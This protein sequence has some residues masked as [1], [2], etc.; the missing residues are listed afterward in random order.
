MREFQDKVAVVTGGSGGIGR[1][2]AQSFLEAGMRVVLADLDVDG[3]KDAEQELS[4]YGTVL[5]IPADVSKR[6][7]VEVL[8]RRAID[9][10]GAVHILCNN[11]GLNSRAEPA[12]WELPYEEWQTVIGVNL[13]GVLNG[14]HVFVPLMLEQNTEGHIVNTASAAGLGSRPGI[15]TY[16]ATKAAVVALSESLHH[17]LAR[18][19][20]K[21]HASVLCPGRV[22]TPVRMGGYNRSR[23]ARTEEESDAEGRKMLH[24]EVGELVLNAIREE[25][26]YV[27]THPEAIKERVRSRADDIL[28]D[29]LPTYSP[30]IRSDSP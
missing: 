20:S 24:S 11:A 7:H 10:F 13:W 4:A 14:M 17:E 28:L 30:S 19:G 25:R 12:L 21:L 3:L 22:R 2:L 27:L 18:A 8:A 16:V 26:F 15:S 23:V 1:G 6:E 5:A 29:R 9:E